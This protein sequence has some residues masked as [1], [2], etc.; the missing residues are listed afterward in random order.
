MW[1]EKALQKEDLL[2]IPIQQID[3]E[4]IHTIGELLEAFGGTSIQARN[5]SLCLQTYRKMLEDRQ[6]I[7]F[8]GLSGPL[9]AAGLRKVLTDMIKKE[10]VDVIVTTG[11]IVYQDFYQALGYSHYQ[12]DPEADD[13]HLREHWVDR[14]YDTYVDEEGFRKTDVLISKIVGELEPKVHSSRELLRFM[15]EYVDDPN[16]IL[17]AAAERGVP[18]FAPAIAD[19]SIGIGL[20]LHYKEHR[21]KKSSFSINPIRDNYEITRIRMKS[22]H[23]GAIFIGGGVPKNYINDTEVTAQLM[24]SDTRGHTYAF[25]LTM[26]MPFWGGLSGSTLKEAK[27]WGKVHGSAAG[28]IAYVEA[29]VSLPLLVGAVLELG[30][31]AGRRVNIVWDGDE[32]EIIS[33]RDKNS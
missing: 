11:A 15:G 3:L 27:S 12:G 29:S 10:L 4:T 22:Q 9:I 16:S 14:I 1:K 25:Q 13:I 17:R 30:Y 31:G 26:D 21:E 5:L 8:L 2:S 28:P 23:S 6:C 7:I 18:V 19:S 24:G 20:T 33:S 32:P